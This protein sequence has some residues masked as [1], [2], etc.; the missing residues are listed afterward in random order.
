MKQKA[1]TGAKMDSGIIRK[2]NRHQER[3][4][5][6]ADSLRE[7]NAHGSPV[8]LS[9]ATKEHCPGKLQIQ[10]QG[11]EHDSNVFELEGGRFGCMLDLGLYNHASKPLHVADIELRWPWK[12]KGERLDWLAQHTVKV[13]NRHNSKITSYQQ[14]QFPGKNGLDL[15]PELVINRLLV[16]SRIVP[17][18]RF[19]SGFLLGI[20]GLMPSDLFHGG[21]IDARLIITTWD[22]EE[23]CEPVRLWTDRL[24]RR[25]PRPARTSGLYERP[26]DNRALE[27][28]LEARPTKSAV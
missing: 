21:W 11:C 27:K 13:R 23:F 25:Q 20:G 19:V 28:T 3:A 17:A 2:Q 22:D 7:L 15:P 6:L 12:N 9:V 10:Q 26:T 24:G 1:F 16:E 8:D 14:Y 5:P 18:R 4:L